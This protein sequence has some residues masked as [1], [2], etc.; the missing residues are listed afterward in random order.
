MICSQHIRNNRYLRQV[1]FQ[2]AEHAFLST[3][4]SQDFVAKHGIPLASTRPVVEELANL[5]H[6]DSTVFWKRIGKTLPQCDGMLLSAVFKKLSK[7]HKDRYDRID[8][9]LRSNLIPG[10]KGQTLD[11]LIQ[12]GDVFTCA[13]TLCHLYYSRRAEEVPGLIVAEDVPDLAIS[14]C[15]P[16]IVELYRELEGELQGAQLSWS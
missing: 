8:Q 6:V 15:H 14:A 12:V 5:L 10:E 3:N 16:K 2:T 1:P 11:M 4:P 13:W 7:E 9:H